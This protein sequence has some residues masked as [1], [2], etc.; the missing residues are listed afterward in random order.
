[1]N[2]DICISIYTYI[3][4]CTKLYVYIHINIYTYIYIYDVIMASSHPG[5]MHRNA[6]QVSFLHRCL[7]VGQ[8]QTVGDYHQV[9]GVA[10]GGFR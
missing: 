1:M 9:N 5:Y 2:I 3:Y 6:M 4:V 8:R 10:V 7:H